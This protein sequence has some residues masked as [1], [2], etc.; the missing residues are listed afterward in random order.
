MEENTNLI[1]SLLEKAGDYGKTRFELVKLKALDKAT[2]VVSSLIPHAV[3]LILFASFMLLVNFGI[4]FWLGEILGNNYYGFFVMAG[5]YV[6]TG[7][8]LQFFFHKKIKNLVWNYMVK[9]VFK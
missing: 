2:D 5:F 3:I 1:E 8:V 7:L 6:I 4:A 9:Q